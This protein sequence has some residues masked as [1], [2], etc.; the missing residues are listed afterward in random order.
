MS[1]IS[2]TF[3]GSA[4]V[5][6]VAACIALAA[7][8]A[9]HAQAKLTFGADINAR[10]AD[11]TRYS[12]GN[13]SQ[14]WDAT[15]FQTLGQLFTAGACDVLGGIDPSQ[16]FTAGSETFV[17][18]VPEPNSFIGETVRTGTITEVRI[19]TGAMPNGPAQ[20]RVTVYSATRQGMITACCIGKAQS[21]PFTLTPDS[22]VRVPVSLK[23]A[24]VKPVL[25]VTYDSLA[26]TMLDN[27]APFPAQVTPGPSF[28][29]RVYAPPVAVGEERFTGGWSTELVPL[30]QADVVIDPPASNG[31][32]STTGVLGMPTFSKVTSRPGKVL[33]DIACS[34]TGA[35]NGTA[36]LT[37]RRTR[38]TEHASKTVTLGSARYAIAAGA[39]KRVTVTLTKVGRNY[40]KARSSRVRATLQLRDSSGKVIRSRA[41]VVRA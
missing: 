13:P 19:K 20:A 11:N 31:S 1:A 24:H 17:V 8:V 29:S 10:S 3:L 33:A 9:A 23:V 12:C 4:T 26:L 30:M 14:L 6:S 18:P 7:P 38:A 5:A 2:R 21:D 34:A 39:R 28:L 27:R 41:V 25:A 40:V 16:N 35:C 37:A 15:Y 36:R 32:G 22:I